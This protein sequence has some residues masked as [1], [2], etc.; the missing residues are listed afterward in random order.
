M[1]AALGNAQWT[2]SIRD[3]ISGQIRKLGS[4]IQRNLGGAIAEAV[5]QSQRHLKRLAASIDRT[6]ARLRYVGASAIASG[7]ALGSLFIYPVKAA[8]S[9]EETLNRLNAVFRLNAKEARGFA[10][11]YGSTVGRSQRQLLGSISDFG[12]FA[13]GLGLG[14][15]EALKFA[16]SVTALS[17]DFASFRDITDEESLRR[18]VAGL[19]GSSEVFKTAGI[20]ISATAL[21]LRGVDSDATQL[22]KT[23]AR[24]AII[25]EAMTDQGALGDATK[26]AKSAT[27][28]YKRFWAIVDDLAISIGN[29][30]LPTLNQLLLY[31][32]ANIPAIK[33]WVDE[34]GNAVKAIALLAV[35]LVAGGGALISFGFIA[36]SIAS[37]IRLLTLTI[38]IASG[39]FNL[40]SRVLGITTKVAIGTVQL[41]GKAAKATGSLISRL[42]KLLFTLV[43]GTGRALFAVGR[44]IGGILAQL[45]TGAGGLVRGIISMFARMAAGMTGI[46]GTIA[47]VFSSVISGIVAAFSTFVSFLGAAFTGL[48]A[49]VGSPVAAVALIVAAVGAAI[50]ALYYNFESFADGLNKIGSGI[51]S[52]FS[53]ILN[54]VLGGI[55]S[56]FSAI[57]G[58]L[59]RITGD[60]YN[61][62]AGAVGS[63][64]D[65]IGDQLPSLP[66]FSADFGFDTA[67]LDE[68]LGDIDKAIAD[69]KKELQELLNSGFATPDLTSGLNDQ[70]A[71]LKAQRSD[72]QDQRDDIEARRRELTSEVVD[73]RSAEG[74]AALIRNSQR[75][76]IP[77]SL[78]DLSQIQ[79]GVAAA[80]KG[81]VP[82]AG[83]QQ[84][85]SMKQ[86]ASD[87]RQIV[88]LLAK[89]NT[90]SADGFDS[91]KSSLDN[92][93]DQIGVADFDT[94][95][96]AP[97]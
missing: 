72:L 64:V 59:S 9:F 25:T 40:F 19:S 92:A 26:T 62:V 96:F 11:V 56:A 27:N 67:A 39:A 86:L 51:L 20:D 93:V 65:Y 10:Q 83:V 77:S 52:F 87:A 73:A 74:L 13:T 81:S 95:N 78:P 79:N 89:G 47:S 66:D 54:S 15:K 45:F 33:K 38:N 7:L 55:K 46:F 63:A 41:G 34:N 32:N 21:A 22:Q 50:A 91:L 49:I 61:G 68:Q 58:F 36:N 48:V 18:F 82:Q 42:V 30:L 4:Q 44:S 76:V 29:H 90:V 57:Y 94:D 35:G 75:G 8:A 37:V 2:V 53:G 43:V 70:L 69:Q 24:L 88:T 23:M 85:N 6:A 14:S 31:I 80:V 84:I 97:V 1:F 5:R 17:V 12:A 71:G 60:I 28:Q 3:L 16:K